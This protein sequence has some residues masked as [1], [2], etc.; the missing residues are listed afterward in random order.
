MKRILLIMV[1]MLTIVG[2]KAQVTFNARVGIGSV[3]EDFGIV[4]I[5]Q[6]N[7]PF[8]RG[9]RFVFSPSLEYN[10]AFPLEEDYDDAY[11]SKI[12][13]GSLNFGIKAPLGSKALLI[14][15]V[16]VALGN[17][18]SGD[19]ESFVFGPSTEIAFEYKHFIVA[20]GGFYSFAET[21]TTYYGGYQA[22]E[23]YRNPWKFSIS[24][25]YK[26]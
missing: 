20:V 5:V 17:D 25:G 26:F 24:L 16:G 23:Y 3:S 8:K 9:G 18:F 21:T 4:G 22:Y 11:G 13:L 15:K 1:M 6:A 12:L 19:V 10:H 14:P 7:I 2:A